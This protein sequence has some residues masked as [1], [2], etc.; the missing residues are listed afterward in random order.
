MIC[1]TETSVASGRREEVRDTTLV[2][3]I[4]SLDFNEHCLTIPIDYCFV[5]TQAS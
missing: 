4:D 1:F 2:D 5:E 3:V